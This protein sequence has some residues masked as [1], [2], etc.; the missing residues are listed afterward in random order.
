MNGVTFVM[1]SR[2][3]PSGTPATPALAYVRSGDRGSSP[4]LAIHVSWLCRYTSSSML[5]ARELLPNSSTTVSGGG[6]GVDGKIFDPEGSCT[7]AGSVR[8][9]QLCCV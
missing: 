3:G 7:I 9:H 2:K 5:T 8:R 6:I 4:G 1:T